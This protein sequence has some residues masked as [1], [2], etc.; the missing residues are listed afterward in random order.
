MKCTECGKNN[1]VYHYVSN[2]NGDVTETHLC[3]ECARKAMQ[4]TGGSRW[5]PFKTFLS[6]GRDTFFDDPLL[7]RLGAGSMFEDMFSEHGPF[8]GFFDDGFFSMPRMGAMMMPAFF[9]PLRRNEDEKQSE[10]SV[11]SEGGEKTA[12]GGKVKAKIDEAF[13]QKREI[14]KLREQMHLAAKN[15]DYEKAAKL[16]DQIKALE[17]R[18]E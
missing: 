4:E 10:E 2:V 15:E 16:R 3:A 12:E 14:R 5:T 1:A 8:G 11:A 9:F 6:D 18:A 17:E 7:R 13:A